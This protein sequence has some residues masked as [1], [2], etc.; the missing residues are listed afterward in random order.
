MKKTIAI[1][2]LLILSISSFSQEFKFTKEGLTDYVVVEI[3]GTQQELY[4]GAIR[5]IKETYMN[6]NEVIQMKIEGEKVRFSGL[7]KDYICYTAI[8]ETACSD[9]RYVI[10]FSFKNSKVKFDPLQLT[11]IADAGTYKVPLNDGS[12]YYKKNGDIRKPMIKAVEGIES[13]FNSLL[14][15]FKNSFDESEEEDW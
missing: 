5:W 10:E 9:G 1:T 3:E 14:Y 7:R 11:S 4:D 6:Y 2:S 13:T 12:G 8:T 15:S